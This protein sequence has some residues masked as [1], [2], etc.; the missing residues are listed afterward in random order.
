MCNVWEWTIVEEIEK[1]WKGKVRICYGWKNK[2]FIFHIKM[3]S[4]PWSEYPH[5][6]YSMCILCMHVERRI[7]KNSRRIK[8]KKN[9]KKT[10]CVSL[11]SFKHTLS[12]Y[13]GTNFFSIWKF[14]FVKLSILNKI[15]VLFV[16]VCVC[17][18]FSLSYTYLPSNIMS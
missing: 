12:V 3:L 1:D 18:I 14:I 4:H 16:S 17:F 6:I 13:C 5:S 11:A 9:K 7:K 2:S 8:K 10:V 15:T